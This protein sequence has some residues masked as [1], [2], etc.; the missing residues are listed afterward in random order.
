MSTQDRER[1][2]REGNFTSP[3]MRALDERRVDPG[4][5]RRENVDTRSPLSA[6]IPRG[7]NNTGAP[8]RMPVKR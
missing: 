4:T 2:P 8:G 7:Q 3:P 6:P 5:V 1:P